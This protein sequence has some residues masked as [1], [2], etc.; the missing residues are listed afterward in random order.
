MKS[1]TFLAGLCTA[2][3][4]WA[5]A[6]QHV[7][8][9]GVITFGVGAS[10][11]YLE[12][13]RQGLREHGYNEGRNIAFEYRFAHGRADSLPAMAAELVRLNP[14]VIVTEGTPAAVSV[15]KVT[16]TIP[17]VMAA[18][19]NPVTIG[20]AASLA[21]PGGNLTGLT[22]AG[23]DRTAKQL[24]LLKESSP[25]TTT[26]AVIYNAA[27][28]GIEAELKGAL[29]TARSLGLTLEPIAVRSPEDLSAAFEAVAKARLSAL[30]TIGDGMLLGN[31]Q[32]IGEFALRSRLPAVFPEREFAD[33]GGLMAYGPD[34][35]S[36]FRRAASYVD[37]ILKGT[38]PADLPVEQPTKWN[39]VVNLRTAKALGLKIPA[40]VLVRADELIQQ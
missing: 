2:A 34:V 16:K 21:R 36:S 29:A 8:K 37:K 24:Q 30:I 15:S 17:I 18:G 39:L 26:V 35:G 23:A 6:A 14:A 38:M 5:A 1:R 40:A 31:S 27:R 20:L 7:P 11:P 28:H 22:L 13:F 4:S 33:A 32:R 9:I 10:S 3:V 25:G 12:A 19:T